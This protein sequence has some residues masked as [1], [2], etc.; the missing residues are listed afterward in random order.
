MFNEKIKLNITTD[1]LF[2]PSRSFG[3]T[4]LG[5]MVEGEGQGDRGRGTRGR[6]EE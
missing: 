2:G 6:E 4:V 1:L 3:L 5:K